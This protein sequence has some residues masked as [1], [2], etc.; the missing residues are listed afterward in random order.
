MAAGQA[1]DMRAMAIALWIVRIL[2]AAIF[3]FFG[4]VKLI[5]AEAEVQLF[6]TVGLG[7][8]FR[9]VTGVLEIVGGI[10]VLLPALSAF[11]AAL[12]LIVDIGA[13]VAQ[14]G[15]LHQDWVHPI[16]FGIILAWLVFIQRRQ[17]FERLG[18]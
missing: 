7:Q 3:L 4:V 1:P 8:W 14:V 2:M 17:I 18:R 10:V 9:Y 11:G 6:D 13:F 16:L 5:G 12:L 15:V